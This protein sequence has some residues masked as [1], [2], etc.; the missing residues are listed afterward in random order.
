MFGKD[1]TSKKNKNKD[2]QVTTKPA[3]IIEPVK[4]EEKNEDETAIKL[5][6][7]VKTLTDKIV[8]QAKLLS[9]GKVRNVYELEKAARE[10]TEVEKELIN[11][12]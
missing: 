12:G 5:I 7:E 1:K 2:F 3:V 9:I 10:L 4:A 6:C 8:E 11:L